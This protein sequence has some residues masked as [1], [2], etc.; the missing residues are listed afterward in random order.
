[1][2][3]VAYRALS[4]AIVAAKWLQAW[5]SH[6]A[7]SP[8]PSSRNVGRRSSLWAGRPWH[9]RPI[10]MSSWP[11]RSGEAG[12]RQA[13][14]AGRPSHRA[15]S[16]H[17]SASSYQA[18]RFLTL[19]QC[20]QVVANGIIVLSCRREYRGSKIMAKAGWRRQLLFLSAAKYAV[21]RS[22]L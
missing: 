4:A 22:S 15:R 18:M 21:L 3:G 14:E 7:R 6:A 10:I 13:G 19:R 16:R 5:Q 8:P 12:R 2:L 11:A 20:H 9:H 1:M 17:Q